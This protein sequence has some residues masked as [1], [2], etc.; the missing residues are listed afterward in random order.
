MK[1][2]L[3]LLKKKNI[4]IECGEICMTFCTICFKKNF[5]HYS[6]IDTNSEGWKYWYKKD[7]V[8]KRI[9]PNCGNI[10]KNNTKICKKCIFDISSLEKREI[11]YHVKYKSDEGN[12]ETDLVSNYGIPEKDMENLAAYIGGWKSKTNVKI[13]SCEEIEE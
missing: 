9:C 13:I 8:K 7:M 1:W 3:S 11:K 12:F 10:L 5:G 6:V 2:F 4:E